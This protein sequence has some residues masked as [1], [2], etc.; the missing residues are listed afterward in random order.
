MLNK[1]PEYLFNI[2]IKG[3]SESQPKCQAKGQTE[4][5]AVLYLDIDFFGRCTN[6]VAWCC[7]MLVSKSTPN[8]TNFILYACYPVTPGQ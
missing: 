3:I 6:K 1:I 8:F 7:I 4:G 5:C 2:W